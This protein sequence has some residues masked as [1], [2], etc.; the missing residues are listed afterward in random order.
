MELSPGAMKA[1]TSA[2]GRD[3]K[4]TLVGMRV[5]LFLVGLI[6]LSS[7]VIFVIGVRMHSEALKVL[8]E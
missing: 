4:L 3:S 8:I 7:V 2:L 6:L 5:T 1:L